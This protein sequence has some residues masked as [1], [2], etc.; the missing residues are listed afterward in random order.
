MEKDLLLIPN[1]TRRE[2]FI[3]EMTR[4]V[5]LGVNDYVAL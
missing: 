5:D 4:L 2:K 3:E 1:R